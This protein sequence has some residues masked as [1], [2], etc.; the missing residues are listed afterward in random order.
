MRFYLG[1]MAGRLFYL[2]A[3]RRREIATKN[4]ALCFPQWQQQQQ[5]ACVKKHFESVGMSLFETAQAW[6]SSDKHLA[7]QVDVEGLEYLHSA[8]QEGKGVIL[9]SAHFT[10]L[11]I[12]GR[13]LSHVAPFHVLYRRHENPVF[14]YNQQA[15]RNRRFEKAIARE[16]MR[17]MIRS[18]RK[19][20]A[21]W[22]AADQNYGHKNS[23]FVDFFGVK[24]ATNTA[25]SR[26][27][28][29]TGAKVVPF[30]V[31]RLENGRYKLLISAAWENFPSTNVD[32]DTQRMNDVIE[33][34]VRAV[35]EQYLWMHRR[36]KDRPNGEKRFY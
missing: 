18:L 35:P 15:S 34:W 32:A 30:S 20:K 11:E 17:G 10:T 31:Q 16:D 23:T 29:M 6:W 3:K 14:E 5:V 2:L 9:L 22:F 27:A 33:Q 21:V 8:L 36:F 1:K 7:K 24:A 19:G 26:L 28:K 12:G 4:I 13:L 25:T